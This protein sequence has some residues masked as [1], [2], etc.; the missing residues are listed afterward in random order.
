[1][2][3]SNIAVIALVFLIGMA[4]GGAVIWLL[5][6]RKS[7]KATPAAQPAQAATDLSFRFSYITLP[8][9]IALGVIITLAILY[10]SLPAEV[11]Y[12]FSSSGSPRDAVSRETFMA[13]MTGVQLVM[14]A[15]AALIAFVILRFARRMLKDSPPLVPPG[16]II[17]LMANMVVMPQLIMAFLALDATYY[18]RTATHMMTPWLF[19]LLTIAIGTL[20][21]IFLFAQSFNETRKAK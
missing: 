4:L 19:S 7:V 13:L 16:R 1:M 11:A 3:S 15:A 9:A 2:T 12:R 21:I 14:V 6:Q 10:S 18:T 5:N 17:W 20:A 8:S